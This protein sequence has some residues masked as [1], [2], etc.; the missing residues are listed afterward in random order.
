MKQRLER[1]NKSQMQNIP[2][3]TDFEGENQ[4]SSQPEEARDNPIVALE[5]DEL[6]QGS[7]FTGSKR[8]D[9]SQMQGDGNL[10]IDSN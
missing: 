10:A 5:P 3:D 8:N 6:K 4:Q 1:L 9:K 7:H 2:G